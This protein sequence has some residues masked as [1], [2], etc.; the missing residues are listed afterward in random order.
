M[1]P[2]KSDRAD[3]GERVQVG[4][5]FGRLWR[6]PPHGSSATLG[7]SHFM[8]NTFIILLSGLLFY[9]CSQKQATPSG[10]TS[11]IDLIQ[12]GTDTTWPG[13]ITLHVTKRDGQSLQGVQINHTLPPDGRK[14]TYTADS[15]TVLPGNDKGD[16]PEHYIKIVIHGAK[17]EGVTASGEKVS[18]V[19]DVTLVLKKQM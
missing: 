7:S 6:A 18:S 5:V 2:N 4:L 8:K 3:E 10:S 16:D 13:D 17:A 15:A 19:E 11:A 1:L 14:V 12:S 9:A